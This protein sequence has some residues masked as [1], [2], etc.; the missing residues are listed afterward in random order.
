MPAT[1]SL[2]GLKQFPRAWFGQFL[3]ATQKFGYKHCQADHTQFIEHKDSKV[4]ALTIYVGNI[5]VKCNDD[6]EISKVKA[7]LAKKFEIKDLGL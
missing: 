5:K 3:K 2:Y 1:K 6:A 4:I 7:Q